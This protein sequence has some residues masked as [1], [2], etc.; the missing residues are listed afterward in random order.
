MDTSN[1]CVVDRAG[2]GDPAHRREHRATWLTDHEH[3]VDAVPVAG[4]P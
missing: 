1:V 4:L 2:P 3:Q